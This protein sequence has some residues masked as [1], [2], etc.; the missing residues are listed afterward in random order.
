MN[1]DATKQGATGTWREVLGLV[2]T[3]LSEPEEARE[4]LLANLAA[5]RPDL[6]LRVRALLDADAMATSVGFMSVRRE[7]RADGSAALQPG[8]RLGPYRIVNEIGKGGMGEVWLARRDDGLYEGE[9]AIKT[10]HPFFAH[11]AMRER[12][13]REAQLLGKLAHPNI[14]R[15]LDAGVSDGVVYIVLEYVD[16]ESIDV[17]C[18][19]RSLDI[20]ARLELF[21]DVCA[22]VSHAHAN[23]V[24]HRDIKPSNILVTPQGQVKL[25]DFGIGKLMD[26]DAGETELTRV[27]G[28]IFTPEFAAPEQVRGE[29]VT[30]ATDVY[31]LGTLLYVLLAGV[32]PFGNEVSGPAAEHAV[33]HLEPESLS[34]AAGGVDGNTAA[35][36]GLSPHRLQRVLANDLEDI[37]HKALRK[38]PGER[39]GSVLA[40]AED[41]QRFKRHEPVLA[42]AGSRGYRFNRFVRRHRVA[43]TASAGVLLAAAVGIAGVLYQ[44]GEAREQARVAKLETAKAT[45]VKD[46]LLQIFES[47]GA[48]HPDGARARLT[49]AE[50]LFDI[51]TEQ[52]IRETDLQPEVRIELME[53]LANLNLQLERYKESEAL[54][55]ERIQVVREK[56]GVAD[57]RLANAH[58]DHA[59][60][61]RQRGRPDEAR[62]QAATAIALR[63]AQGDRNS[64]TR[65]LA[66]IEL[67]QIAYGIWDGSNNEPID[68]FLAAIAILE[69]LEPS[70]ELARAHLGLARAYEYVS[71]LDEAIAS[72]ERGIALAI[73]I[74]GP[75]TTSV[76]GGHQQLAR[77][78]ASRHRLDEAE[79]H[80]AKAVEIFTFAHGA[81]SGFTQGALLE[82]GRMKSRR[83]QHRAAIDVLSPVLERYLLVDGP[84]NVRVQQARQALADAS[85]AIG[86]FARAK[87]LLDECADAL[88][89]SKNVRLRFGVARSLAIL[90][91][92]QG[93]ADAALAHLEE[94]ERFIAAIPGPSGIPT[95][96]LLS[97]RS[98]AAVAAGNAAD[99]RSAIS[100]A[101]VLLAEFDKDP[102]KIES[103]YL[104]LAEAG[105]DLRNSRIAE[106]RAGAAFV[107]ARTGAS[108]RRAELWELEDL[109]QRRFAAAELASGNRS[110][111]CAAWDAAIALRTAHALPSDPR[112]AA[113]R[114]AKTKC[115]SR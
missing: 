3:L 67:G 5:S 95:A 80:L 7:T 111:A 14:A 110:A 108:R 9:V 17:Y 41:L 98:E 42:R 24:I 113:S 19:V 87:A 97:T 57:V 86:D 82:V 33:L 1:E 38:V 47:N 93:R 81:D 50:E 107:L 77:V 29:T 65:G 84:R 16:G 34:R 6:H 70:H 40:L 44:A 55:L 94:A 83:G 2:D 32:R 91:L 48:R 114:A 101:T 103:L 105:A 13:L 31:S 69:K 66:E 92:E 18:D 89:S 30:T 51:A 52:V 35:R 61:L 74:D 60:F 90:A 59:E 15:L 96:Q 46:F 78:L 39:Y 27:S 23:L 115:S 112:I 62:A 63:E 71:R 76:A 64:W 25:L 54:G 21:A 68:H 43:V 11:G 109:A 49:T 20:D 102:E 22:A 4:K 28:R 99:A 45:A 73:E 106:A 10:L 88:R 58:L 26:A 79:Q 100:K 85:I 75:R 72:N 104:R 36:R 12:F 8:A 56:L 37:A 53:T